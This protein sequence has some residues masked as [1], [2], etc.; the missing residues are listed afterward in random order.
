MVTAKMIEQLDP[1]VAESLRRLTPT[2]RVQQAFGSNRLVRKRLE[3]HFLH[4]HPDWPLEDIQK[5]LA[6]RVLGGTA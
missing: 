3:A 6:E 1:V 4:Q 5:A 2:Q